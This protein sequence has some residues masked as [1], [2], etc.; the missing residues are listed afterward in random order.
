MYMAIQVYPSRP[1]GKEE[2]RRE[3]NENWGLWQEKE[4]A[5]GFGSF[6]LGEGD[7]GRGLRQ[8]RGGVGTNTSIFKNPSR[9]KIS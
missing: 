8:E 2:K 1:S 6:D 4:D 5:I 9:E 3:E 7:W